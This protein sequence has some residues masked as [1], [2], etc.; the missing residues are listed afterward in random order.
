MGDDEVIGGWSIDP[1]TRAAM[2]LERI[3]KALDDGDFG[4]AVVE[5]EELLDEDPEHAEGTFLLAEA[6][7][8]L[9]DMESAVETYEIHL[10]KAGKD[11]KNP[12]SPAAWTGLA[13]SRFECCD[14]PGAV[15]AAR[16]AVS[17]ASDLADAHHI[18]GLALERTPGKKNESIGALL[19]AH[20]LDPEAY[21]LP[22]HL[23]KKQWEDLVKQARG[24]IPAR[25]Q[26]F[27]KGVPFV[28]EDLPPIDM[29]KTHE[30]PMS[31]LVLGIYEGEPPDN[32]AD[33][34][35]LRPERLR[36]FTGNIARAGRKDLAIDEI[37]SVLE[38]EALDWLALLPEDLDG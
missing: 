23:E 18:L 38:S 9:G 7:L 27:W 36:W 4:L 24:R 3:H 37:A 34:P 30:P 22:L 5:A 16:Q 13:V 26:E 15:E 28:Y 2:R 19:A 32:P 10:E 20:R 11:A 29:L 6:L 21:P 14:M 25:L 17:L 12:R 35:D 31:P 8:E 1:S 33:T